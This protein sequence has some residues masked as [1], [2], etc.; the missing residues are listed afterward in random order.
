V[1]PRRVNKCNG[2]LSTTIGSRFAST[3]CYS[4]PNS[5]VVYLRKASMRWKRLKTVILG[6]LVIAALGFSFLF[7]SAWRT[8]RAGENFVRDLRAMDVG[9]TSFQQVA[10][11]RRR[12]SSYIPDK[13]DTC[14]SEDCKFTVVFKNWPALLTLRESSLGASVVFQKGSLQQVGLGAGCAGADRKPP[15]IGTFVV[16]VNRASFL[17]PGVHGGAAGSGNGYV[18]NVGSGAKP[19]QLAKV[20]GFNF[21]FLNR[22]GGCRDAAEM[23]AQSPAQWQESFW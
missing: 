22:F 12:Y 19:E 11:L 7:Y 3:K 6:L 2:D 9:Q 5:A 15:Y 14:T 1:R 8:R 13:A 17:P 20:Y 18:F 10:S 4:H 21:D 16:S 23:F